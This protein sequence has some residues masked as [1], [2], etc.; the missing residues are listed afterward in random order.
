MTPLAWFAW[1][2]LAPGWWAAVEQIVWIT[3]DAIERAILMALA[4]HESGFSP[5]VARCEKGTTA[6]GLGTWQIIPRSPFEREVACS[7][8]AAYV[9]LQRVQES[10]D[11]C[12]ALP[13]VDRLA[14]YARGSCASERGRELSRYRMHTALKF[15]P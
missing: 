6:G 7:G 13:F 9:A 3:D 11:A 2:A 12:K 4:Q 15:L 1:A 5:R 8:D 14:V 10:L